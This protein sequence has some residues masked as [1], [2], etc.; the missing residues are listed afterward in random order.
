MINKFKDKLN[1][2][3]WIKDEYYLIAKKEIL[4]TSHQGMKILQKLALKANSILDLGC[5]EGTRLNLISTR[6]KVS[7]GV[8]ISGTAI[9][10]AK[11][12]YPNIKF[13]N[14]DLE[15]IPLENNSFDL[16][17]SAF[18]LEH[19]INP[20]RV[21]SEAI[22]LTKIRRLLVLIAPNY[23]A[24]NRA[25]PP[26][27]GNRVKKLIFGFINDFLIF[28]QRENKLKW[29]KVNPIAT[30]DKYDIDW[31]TTIEPYVGNLLKFLKKKH[32]RIKYFTTCWSEETLNA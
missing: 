27:K 23:G 6:K 8:D 7:I 29:N 13:I 2:E 25:S 22:R 17:Y 24:P 1:K 31:D 14:A 12:N 30:L 10:M 19:L 26:F 5:G 16:V 20:V 11:K 4:E 21:L 9:R 18:V 32:M 3:V 28:F 15:N